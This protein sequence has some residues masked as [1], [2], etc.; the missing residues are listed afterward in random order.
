MIWRE[1]GLPN[2]P[3][4]PKP[5]PRGPGQQRKTVDLASKGQGGKGDRYPGKFGIMSIMGDTNDNDEYFYN[6]DDDDNDNHHEVMV[7]DL[8]GRVAFVGN[9]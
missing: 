7:I 9:A 6:L 8:T 1:I 2:S 5:R 3:G 4:G